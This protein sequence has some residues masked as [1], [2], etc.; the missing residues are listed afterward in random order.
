MNPRLYMAI[1]LKIISHFVRKLSYGILCLGLAIPPIMPTKA[2][3]QS[4]SVGLSKYRK[5][6][7]K[8][9][10]RALA[11]ALKRARSNGAKADIYRLLGVIAHR[12]GQDSAAR[13]Y[14]SSALRLVPS[15]R[16]KKSETLD[17]SVTSFFNN[18]RRAASTKKVTRAKAPRRAP[19]AARRAPAPRRAPVSTRK[20]KRTTILIKSNVPVS[21]AID[22]IL[23][24]SSGRDLEV[25]PGPVSLELKATGYAKK[26]IRATVRARTQN[27]IR[28]NMRKKVPKVVRKRAP[29]PRPAPPVVRK[30]A[31]KKKPKSMFGDQQPVYR[32]PPVVRKRAPSQPQPPYAPY[33]QPPYYQPP[34]TPIPMIVP[35]PVPYAAP[36]AP[37][38]GPIYGDGLGGGYGSYGSYGSSGGSSS[39][40]YFSSS[41]GSMFKSK[42]K[43]ER[44]GYL[45][46]SMLPFGIGQFQNGDY[47]LGGFFALSQIGAGY[48]Y[49][50]AAN[51]V[52]IS[53]EEA[54]EVQ[55]R[56]EEGDERKEELEKLYGE[57]EAY[58]NEQVGFAN[59]M[60]ALFGVLYVSG[61]IEAIVN[62]PYKR[63]KKRRY[64]LLSERQNL[65]SYKK[66]EEKPQRPLKPQAR[67]SFYLLDQGK[68][69]GFGVDLEF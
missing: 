18:V 25:D 42:K 11:L 56:I 31:P 54:A 28:V 35:T 47:L 43:R 24:G 66:I 16:I 5:G 1:I 48:G 60:V 21:V 23:A 58:I 22:G 27:V 14:F 6:Q 17:P 30:R 26:R 52:A 3:G 55:K 61:V 9:A 38:Q 67:S 45:L 44:S 34:V 32:A 57:Q 53:K 49:Y 37:A 4:Y 51:E 15:T 50:Y 69:Y 20:S 39:P 59:A 29:R 63:R 12:R 64:G 8:A 41:S 2:Y 62:R 33:G 13:T 46:V 68:A 65:L 19:A 7:L 40:D 10:N 36:Q